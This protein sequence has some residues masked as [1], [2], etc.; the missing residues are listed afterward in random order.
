VDELRVVSWFSCGAASAVATKLAIAEF[1]QVEI[2]YNKV[3]EEHP[4]NERFLADCEQWFGQK[5]IITMNEYYGGSIYR[6]F[7]TNYMRTPSGSPCTRALKKQV[8]ERFQRPTD[9]QILGYTADEMVRVN[10]FID[11]NN[12]IDFYP[13]L[14]DKGLTKSDCLAMV[15]RAGI[16]LPVLY[17]Q[18]YAHNN[19]LGCVKAGIGYWNKLR[20]DYPAVFKKMA[21]FE[22]RKGY[23]VLKDKNGPLYLHDLDPLRGRM[24]DEPEISCGV[25]C[26][27][28]ESDYAA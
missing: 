21:D 14:V 24:E 25:F 5:V 20:V 27:A 9:K 12:D 19:C 7:E 4:D 17:L 23:T 3:I 22:R 16:T 26:E 10:R 6:V 18:G 2:V 13:I 11:G 8:R 1:D 28:A 15:E